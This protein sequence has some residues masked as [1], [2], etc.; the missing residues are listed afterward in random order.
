RLIKSIKKKV[1]GKMLYVY[2]DTKLREEEENTLYRELDDGKISR[3]ELESEIKKAGKIL[4]VSNIDSEEKEIYDMYKDREEIEQ[5]FDTYKNTLHA[6]IMYLQDD[7][8]VFG[9]VFISF[10]TLYGYS[11]IQNMLREAKLLNKIS[12]LDVLEEFSSVYAISDG[13]KEIITEVPK[14]ARMLDEKLKTNLFPKNRS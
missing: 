5:Q 3:D 1:D 2:E 8:S 11:R 12:P 6:D 10:L 9:H 7:E 4:I 13:E 14:K